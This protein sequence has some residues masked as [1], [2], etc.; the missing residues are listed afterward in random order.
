MY[1]CVYYTSHS[2]T[3]HNARIAWRT[4]R[5]MFFGVLLDLAAMCGDISRGLPVGAKKSHFGYFDPTREYI[6]RARAFAGVDALGL[7]RSRRVCQ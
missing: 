1:K 4:A 7:A 2:I 3:Q 5:E 6:Q